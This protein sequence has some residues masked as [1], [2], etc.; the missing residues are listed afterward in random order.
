MDVWEQELIWGS[1]DD[2][3]DNSVIRHT[4]DSEEYCITEEQVFW[5]SR[6]F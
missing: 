4:G 3:G 6:A 1:R 5:L 2:F